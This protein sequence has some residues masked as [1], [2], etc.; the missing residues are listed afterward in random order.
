M[1]PLPYSLLPSGRTRKAL[2]GAVIGILTVAAVYVIGFGFVVQREQGQLEKLKRLPSSASKTLP[3]V[4]DL[5]A[6]A[7]GDYPEAQLFECQ[8]LLSL[9]RKR[10]AREKFGTISHLRSCDPEGLFRFGEKA[11]AAEEPSL[12]A[13]AFLAAGDLVLR[14]PRRLKLM[15]Y[16]LYSL[17]NVDEFEDRILILSQDYSQ[18][19]PDD[20]FPWLVRSSLFH[21]RG[22]PN[23]AIQA[24]REALK[25]Q[26]SVEEQIR[27]RLH[28]VQ[29]ELLMGELPAA[30]EHCNELLA[31][32][33]EPA[34][35]MIATGLNA[36]LLQREGKPAE[37]LALLD[38]LLSKSPDRTRAQALRG[39]CKYDLGDFPGAI[40]DLEEA[41]R[42][43][44][45]DQQSH[46]VL[47]QAYRHQK[48][49]NS[50][51]QHLARSRELTALMAQILTLENQLRNDLYN[52]ELKLQLAEL[53]EK[54]GDLEKAAA[55]RRGAEKKRPPAHQ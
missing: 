6:S 47:S 42:L 16:T 39:R 26:L 5:I 53:N 40:T 20:P 44:Q 2:I 1:E 31:A 22:V 43:N 54:C 23:L 27:V 49:E 7:D 15:I 17:P 24:Y 33:Q 45:V 46:Y 38:G 4:Q 12:A 37:A 29:L 21:E 11:L 13:E 9:G 25:R 28:L 52:R 8:L 36:D 32:T 50:A 48:D 10:E 3:L 34:S 35:M 19:A 51:N 14:D 41:V 55:W 18:L 30:R